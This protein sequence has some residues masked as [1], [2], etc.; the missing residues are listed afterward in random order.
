MGRA[1]RARVV[2]TFD[3][4]EPMVRAVNEKGQSVDRHTRQ[5]KFKT[6]SFGGDPNDTPMPDSNNSDAYLTK[7]MHDNK[8]AAILTKAI[9]GL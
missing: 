1:T 4:D 7:A 8:R 5:L 9:H 2:Q 6:Y 3:S